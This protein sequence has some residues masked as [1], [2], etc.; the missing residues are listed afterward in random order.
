VLKA[1]PFSCTTAKQHVAAQLEAAGVA[2]WRFDLLPL[3]ASTQVGVC[4]RWRLCDIPLRLCRVLDWPLTVVL[5]AVLCCAVLCCAVL[6][7]TT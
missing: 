7:R 2:S 5:L 1:K 6:C 4:W 3:A